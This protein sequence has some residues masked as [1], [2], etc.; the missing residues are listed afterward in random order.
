MKSKSADQKSRAFLALQH[1]FRGLI[2]G[3]R[4]RR[5]VKEVRSPPSRQFRSGLSEWML[6]ARAAIQPALFRPLLEW[7]AELNATQLGDLA[8]LPINYDELGGIYVRAPAV[9][10]EQELLWITERVRL[11]AGRISAFLASVAKIER[12]AFL[13]QHE[14]A[15]AEIAVIQK[16]FGVTLWSVQ[17]RLALEHLAGGLERQKRYSAEVRA[18]YRTG[19]LGFITYHSS[20]RNEDRTTLAKF[21]E[22]I[23]RRIE[24]HSKYEDATK[25]YLRYRLKNELPSSESGLADVLRVEQSHGLLDIY[26]TFIAVLQE[27]ARREPEPKL[28]GLIV[29]CICS[30]TINDFR[31]AKIVHLLRPEAAP[32]LPPRD[33]R[34]PD[35]L[36][37]G[38]ALSAARAARNGRTLFSAD[39][40]HYIY[41]GFAL[42]YLVRTPKAVIAKPAR[43]ADLIA[44]VQSR[45]DGSEDAWDQVT[46]LALNSRGLPLGAGLFDFLIQL[47]RSSPDQPWRPWLIGLNSPVT[48][49]ED[50]PWS[51]GCSVSADKASITACVWY[52]A[53]CP[54]DEASYPFRLARAAGYIHRGDFVLAQEALGGRDDGWPEP[55]RSL[56]ALLLLHAYHARGERQ[57]VIALI[58]NEGARSATH[59]RFLPIAATLS[60]YEWSDYKAVSHP[61]AAAIALNLLWSVTEKSLV[62]SQMRFATGAALRRIGVARPSKLS[63][64]IA[65]VERHELVYFLRYLC[66]PNILDLTRLF[67]SSRAIIEERQLIC[68]LLIEID[69]NCRSAY[70]D[71][72][73]LIGKELALDEGRWIVD[74]TRIHVDSEALI[75]W[76]TRSLAEDYERYRDLAQVSVSEPQA[77]EDVLRELESMASQRTSFTAENE[78][79]AVLLSILHRLGEEFLTNA[80]FGLDFYISKR[81][82]HQSFIGLIRGPLEF[83]GLTTTRESEVGEYH[84]N[85]EWV[86][87]FECVD[88]DARE[89]IDEALRNFAARFD[90]ILGKAKDNLFHLRSDDKP[91][92]MIF[93]FIGENL[94]RLARAIINLEFTFQE[95]LAV[96]V[97]I[98]WTAIEPSLRS[99]RNYIAEE[100]KAELI[101]EF[102]VVRAAVRQVAEQDP[103][104]LDFDAAMGKGSAEVQVKLDEAANWFVHADTL[105]HRRLFTLDQMIEIGIDTALK[106]QRGYAP[107]ITQRAEG[108][109]QLYAP[110]LVFFHDVLF[111]GLGNAHKHSGLKS[112]KIDIMAKWD[113][114]NATITLGVVS[115]CKLGNRAEKEKQTDLIRQ[116]INS[117]QLSPRTRTEGGSGFA[118]LAAVVRQ[119]DRG[120]LEFG[121]T[122]EG[123]FR[124]VVTYAV[125][126]PNRERANA[127]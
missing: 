53:S 16:D 127:A 64:S 92:G 124:L 13:E 80:T 52:E 70:E 78:A 69:P 73:I 118:K 12:A 89:K 28:A 71:E 77:F 33:C 27:I 35:H 81:V 95:F 9:P 58:A 66:V 111:V 39:P 98:L 36:F 40:W 57:K 68:S 51:R 91:Q 60:G 63:N 117:G 65:G 86:D 88:A 5:F 2:A 84:R 83:A 108:D 109:L 1:R 59:A 30:L 10:L 8:H 87:R 23:E 43:V 54:G 22:G 4:S 11:E 56:R 120:R 25:T 94:V 85:H 32:S 34:I 126:L 119:S 97:P 48:G 75:R 49:P 61:F 79:D 20:V 121:F 37:A 112:P 46:K 15:I 123:R 103:S 99:I 105:K 44:R 26:E 76:A 74:S 67:P 72:I 107:E 42:S 3:F 100:M 93:L 7:A 14:E 90:E 102:D 47:R 116:A 113:A 55:L 96:A 18:V 29:N 122:P 45:C 106:T 17:L 19:L 125:L 115:D 104:F 21:I 82:R 101:K 110:D 50:R 38:R 41:A 24:R 114:D 62:A 31:L 6:D